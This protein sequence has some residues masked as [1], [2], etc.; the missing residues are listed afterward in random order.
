VGFLY[1]AGMNRPRIG[2]TVD[3]RDRTRA[4]GKYDS[5]VA[6]SDAIVAAGGAPI[7]LPHHPELADEYVATCEGVMLTGGDDPTMEPFGEPT[8]PEARAIDPQ[9]Q[10]FELAM[11][12][13][14]DAS[15][16]TPVLAVCLGMQLMALRS[17][18]RLHQYLPEV[19]INPSMHD[20]KHRHE[21]VACLDDGA[22]GELLRGGGTVVSHHRQAVADAGSL[23]VIGTASDGV[24]EAID[25]PE[26][27]FCV[28]VQWH[29]ERGDEGPL[30]L[31]LLQAFVSASR[32]AR[33]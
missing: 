19:L 26:R 8:H 12:E 31:G 17:G 4:S 14:L 30:N 3:N 23:R 22:V 20:G 10:A 9:R 27:P 13:A 15:P 28:G 29:P 11:L 16:T 2:I 33:Q 7:L 25:D 24:I 18:G 32:A 6:Y 1:N 21:I 5:S